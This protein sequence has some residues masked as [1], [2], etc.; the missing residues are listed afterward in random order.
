MENKKK[1]TLMD[2]AK[3]ADAY[4]TVEW[5]PEDVLHHRP[6]WSTEQAREFLK[7]VELVLAAGILRTGWNIIETL[8]RKYEARQSGRKGSYGN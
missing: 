2:L 7:E 6:D 3:P 8:L 4:A 5:T 1:L